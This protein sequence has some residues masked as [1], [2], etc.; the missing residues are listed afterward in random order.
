ME[1]PDQILLKDLQNGNQSAYE[2]VFKKYYKAL[3]LKAYLMLENEMEAEDL[4]QNLFISMWEKSQFLSVN[5][6]LKAY[7]FKAVHNQCL[8]CLRKRK[9]DQQ[10]LDEYTH[11][12]DLIT[13]EEF[14]SDVEHEKMI[15]YALEELPTQRQKAFQLVYLEDKK[16]KEAA[17]EM[18]LSVNSV[19][20]HLKLA[21]KMLQEKLI[22][23]R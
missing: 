17:T 18:G 22:S 7:L 15:Q 4:V 9:T 2:L 8:M 19:K 21:I 12:L 1:I 11:T 5:T 3:A 13:D 10:R 20:T 6:A 23:F 14:L 16:Y